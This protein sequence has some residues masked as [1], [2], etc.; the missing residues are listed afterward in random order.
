MHQA[1]HPSYRLCRF[2]VQTN[3]EASAVLSTRCTLRVARYERPKQISDVVLS[4]MGGWTELE[5]ARCGC[6]LVL[7]SRQGTYFYKRPLDH[8]NAHVGHT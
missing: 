7:N 2:S 6:C 4:E 5:R 3:S 1:C 8:A